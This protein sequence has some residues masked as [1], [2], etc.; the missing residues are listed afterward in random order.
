MRWRTSR[1]IIPASTSTAYSTKPPP[2]ALP[3]QTRIVRSGMRSLQLLDGRVR[4][5]R[6]RPG[7]LGP[8]RGAGLPPVLPLADDDVDLE[9]LVPFIGIV[10][11]G[12]RP[13]ALLPQ[14]GRPRDRLRRHEER[15]H[16]QGLVPPGVVLRGP[17]DLHPRRVAFDPLELSESRLELRLRADDADVAPHDLLEVLMDEI[18][19]RPALAFQEVGGPPHRGHHAIVLG[20]GNRGEP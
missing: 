20:T 4:Y 11:P 12:V 2:M 3:R 18:G 9:P 16:V 6:E 1:T 7:S 8:A 17:V 19:V 10:E 15:V 5:R 14:K 13:P